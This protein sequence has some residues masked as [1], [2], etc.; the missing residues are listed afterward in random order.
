MGYDYRTGSSSP[1]GSIAPLDRSGY[2]IRD[3]VI[4][5]SS[6]VPASKL[7]LGVPYYGRAW[8]TDDDTLNASNI[9][10]TKYGASTTVVYDTAADYLAQYG[11]RYD[12]VEEVAWTA[13]R[14]QNCT[15]TYGCVT[16]WRELYVDDAATLGQKYDLVNQYGLRGAGIWALGYDGTRPE[17]WKAIYTK[18]VNDTK[19][20]EVGVRTLPARMVNPGFLVTWTGYD[21][22]G[23]ASYD[24]QVSVDGGAWTTWVNSTR[25]TSW[26]WYGLDNHHYAFRVRARDFK[27]NVSAWNVASDLPTTTASLTVGGF[28]IVDVDGLAVRTF[29]DPSAPQL[30]SVDSGDL[31]GIVGGP[32]IARGYTWYQIVGPLSTWNAVQPA[33]SGGWVAV[34]TADATWVDPA[35]PPNAT[36]VGAYLGDLTFTGA[37]AASVGLGAAAVAL[38]SFSPNGDGSK[39]A[40]RLDWTN[41]VSLDSLVLR[42]FRADG[43]LLGEVPLDDLAAGPAA[44]TWNGMVGGSRLPN[45][46]YLASLVGRAGTATYYNPSV[47]FRANAYLTYYLTI[48]TVAPTVRSAS[49]SGG[50]LSPNGDGVLDTVTASLATADGATWAF[51]VAP[52][53]GSTV[54]AP[55]LVRTGSGAAATVTWDGRNGSGGVVAD[56]TYQ[57]QIV[58]ADAAGNRTSRSWTVRVDRTAPSARVSAPATF[59]PNGDGASDTARLAWSASEPI[60]GTAR[61]LRG[62]TLIRSWSLSAAAAGAVMWDG[63]SASGVAVADGTYTFNVVGRD[64][65]GNLVSTSAFVTVDRTLSTL[66]WSPTAFYPQDG[67]ALFRTSRV[68]FSTIRTATV[69]ATIYSGQTVIRRIMTNA[70]LGAGAH[71]WTWDGRDDA[72][73]YVPRGT[74]VVLVKATSAIGTSVLTRAVVADSYTVGLSSTSLSAGQTLTVTF[75]STEPLRAAPTVGFTQPGRS[76]VNKTAT[77]LGGGQYRVVFTVASGPA[78]TAWVVISGRD[79]SGGY[80]ATSRTV[81]IH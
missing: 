34:A 61:I 46:R 27:G 8:S 50:I 65:A 53:T 45:G 80:N 3:T 5:Y 56:G 78:G 22:V 66:R 55:I 77:S 2:D 62:S 49:I 38:R 48:D 13:Y 73:A 29:G 31:L 58:A 41:A 81:A 21:D 10:G 39:D 24:T 52:V 4:A 70:T 51:G 1:V 40:I 12:P 43:A 28:G 63:R 47:D 19:P 72:G 64:V 71:A 14:R 37:G 36:S 11:R 32:R 16:A 79:T 26:V 57:L 68:S 42:V 60:S 17:L 25:A 33:F 75:T 67:D 44:A 35:K 23:I 9:S 69:T 18:F 76:V 7:I 59:S 30:G 74:Y 54:G 6:R 15:T 20:P